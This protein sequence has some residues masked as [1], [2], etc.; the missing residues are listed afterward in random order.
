MLAEFGHLLL[1]HEHGSFTK[2]AKLAHLS[3]PAL[4]MA[5]ARLEDQMGA[6]L[7]DR[8][9]S[10]ATLTAAGRTLLPFARSALSAIEDGRRAVAE[11]TALEAG[12]VRVGGGATTCTYILPAFLVDFHARHPGIRMHL[13]EGTTDDNLDALEAGELDLCVVTQAELG[14]AHALH[15]RHPTTHFERWRDDAMEL[16]AAPAWIDAAGDSAN[17][18]KAIAAAPFVT[19][20]VGTTR[21]LLDRSFPD[22]ERIME[23]G[24]LAAIKGNVRA[25]IGL[26]L[27]SRSAIE[28]DLELGALR[29]LEHPLTPIYYTLVLAHRGLD[30]L[31]PAAR[32]L[33]DLLLLEES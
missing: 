25:G 11:L 7:F 1:I 10:G 8:G 29:R 30:R 5:I 16:V 19:F 17:D 21:A 27:L 13:R 9:R 4:S 12:Q 3:Q 32:A 31:P 20:R 26:A 15:R 22:A 24:S 14:P 28:R 2:A 23:L 18:P 33:R 6:R